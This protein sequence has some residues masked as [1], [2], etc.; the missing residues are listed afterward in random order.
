L[1]PTLAACASTHAAPASDMRDELA[2]LDGE[3][4]LF[5]VIE[6]SLIAEE[7]DLMLKQ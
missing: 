3:T 1:Q 5:G 7:N 2:E 6:M 4:L